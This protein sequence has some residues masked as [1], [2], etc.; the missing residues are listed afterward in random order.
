[1]EMKTDND[2]DTTKTAAAAHDEGDDERGTRTE[3]AGDG[4]SAV[5]RGTKKGLKRRRRC[6]LGR[7]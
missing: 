7:R 5:R 3:G 6:L 2:N 1:M 4:Y